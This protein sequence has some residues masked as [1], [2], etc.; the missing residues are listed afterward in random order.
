[1]ISAE[2]QCRSNYSSAGGG[3]AISRSASLGLAVRAKRRSAAISPRLGRALLDLDR[4][5]DE[6]IGSIDA[7]IRERGYAAYKHANSDLAGECIGAADRPALFV[8]SSGFLTEDNPQEMLSQ[9]RRL[10]ARTYSLSLLPSCDIREAAEILVARQLG[11]GFGLNAADEMRKAETRFPTYAAAGD[12]L[13]IS[14]GPPEQIAAYLAP[15]LR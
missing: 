15:L 14:R 12:L 10:V 4:L 7:Y 3:T 11:R 9:N 13:V 8:T 5:F 6:R 2:L 1:M